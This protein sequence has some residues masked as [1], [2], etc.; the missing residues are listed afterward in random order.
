MKGG[1]FRSMASAHAG[2]KLL[3]WPCSSASCHQRG[4]PS[5]DSVAACFGAGTPQ[6]AAPKMH[7]GN[8][9]KCCDEN[10]SAGFT[11]FKTEK[12]LVPGPRQKGMETYDLRLYSQSAQCHPRFRHIH[13]VR[14]SNRTSN[15]K[16]H[17]K[18]NM[19]ILQ[20]EIVTAS[21]NHTPEPHRQRGPSPWGTWPRPA[22]SSAVWWQLLQS[23][24]KRRRL[25]LLMRSRPHW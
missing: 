1:R 3:R 17:N 2:W 25:L 8:G 9:R 24:E 22:T 10:R 13:T 4:S 7:T 12:C 20:A 5:H 6:P 19:T 14:N 15:R 16:L 18:R 11:L 23:I 21:R